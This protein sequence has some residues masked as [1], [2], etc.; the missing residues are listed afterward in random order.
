MYRMYAQGTNR[1]M[2]MD[3]GSFDALVLQDCYYCGKR[4]EAGVHCNGVDRIDSSNRRYE[5]ANVVPCC[6]TCNSLK[7]SFS[8]AKFL[9]HVRRVALHFDLPS[10]PL[11]LLSQP[12]PGSSRDNPIEL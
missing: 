7:W 3:K 2:A 4:N 1:V 9:Q 11:P 6:K 8:Q 12:C 5:T 10:P